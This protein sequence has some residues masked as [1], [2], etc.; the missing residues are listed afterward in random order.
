[1]EHHFS[2]NTSHK[3]ADNKGMRLYHKDVY[4]PDNLMNLCRMYIKALQ[5][6]FIRL[7]QHV[8]D[9][10]EFNDDGASHEYSKDD[11][12]GAIDIAKRKVDTLNIFEAGFAVIPG[13]GD[14]T[15]LRLEKVAF[16]V[17]LDSD[18]DLAVVIFKHGDVNVVATAWINDKEDNHSEGF[19]SSRYYKPEG[20]EEPKKEEPPKKKKVVK[21]NNTF[22]I[23]RLVE[24][25]SGFEGNETERVRD[26]INREK[27]QKIEEEM[28]N[29][30]RK[31]IKFN[32]TSRTPPK[33]REFTES[34]GSKMKYLLSVN[35]EDAFS[36]SLY[37]Y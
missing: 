29:E 33:D 5:P 3:K 2:H 28:K 30:A 26:R 12:Y 20:Y 15:R 1:M 37:N 35:N 18:T 19:N 7:S 10:T 25:K 27:Q 14:K 31:K 24:G 4:F 13:E 22:D 36:G 8:H 11:I 6:K 16:R 34:Y 32:P 9:A 23:N 17:A 21:L